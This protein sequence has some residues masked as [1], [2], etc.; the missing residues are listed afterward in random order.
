MYLSVVQVKSRYF[1]SKFIKNECDVTAIEQAIVA[2][3]ISAVIMF[4]FDTS[5]SGLVYKMLIYVF[6]TLGCKL[7][8][9]ID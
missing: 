9:I 6:Q 2:A 8:S 7:K 1:S 4:I 3:G 5:D